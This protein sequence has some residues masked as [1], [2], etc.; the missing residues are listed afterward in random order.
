MKSNPTI[1]RI[2]AVALAAV[3]LFALALLFP[4]A[5][6]AR[7]GG[8]SHCLANLHLLGRAWLLYA[9]DN[10]STLVRIVTY[11]ADG[12]QTHGYP[13]WART[14][15]IRVKNFVA[16]P[17]DENRQISAT[18]H[19]KMKFVASSRAA[20]GLSIPR[21]PI[22]YTTRPLLET[23]VQSICSSNPKRWLRTY[24]LGNVYN[25]YS[26]NEGWNTGEMYATVYKTGEIKSPSTKL[27]FLEETDGQGYNMN[28]WDIF[29]NDAT[30]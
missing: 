20:C 7:S 24:S 18:K 9:E 25:G 23:G 17:Q 3:I 11:G 16:Y 4:A 28:V 10:D 22:I 19:W 8:K 1:T 29:L 14:T 26:I 27:V 21:H 5:S 12:W 13:A 30:R 2:Q 6:T 15:T